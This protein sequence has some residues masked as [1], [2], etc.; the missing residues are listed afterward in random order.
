MI[1]T[2]IDIGEFEFIYFSPYS[3]LKREAKKMPYESL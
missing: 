1:S 3:T 2:P